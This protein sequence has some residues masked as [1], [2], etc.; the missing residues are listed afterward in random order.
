MLGTLSVENTRTHLHAT[1]VT[2]ESVFK[3]DV[4]TR[5]VPKH[6][7]VDLHL[8]RRRYLRTRI[9]LRSPALLLLEFRTVRNVNTGTTM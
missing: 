2:V 9:E 5:G 6:G 1:D 7:I 4:W 3:I 8:E